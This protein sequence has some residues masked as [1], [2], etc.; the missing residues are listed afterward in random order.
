MEQWYRQNKALIPW[1]LLG[2]EAVYLLGQRLY[3]LKT[4]TEQDDFVVSSPLKT[5]LPTLSD[6]EAAELPYPPDAYPGARDVES[7]YGSLRVY[8]WG[9]EDG[10][11]VLLIHGISSPCITLGGIAHGLVDKGCRVILLDLPGRG[12]SD[13][14]VPTPHS[15]RLYTTII[16]LA[17]A[18]SPISW[19]GN[20]NR[21]SL[22]GYSFGGGIVANFTSYFPTLVESLVLLAPGGLIR[23]EHITWINKFLYHTRLINETTLEGI[24]GRG[25]RKNSLL[26]EPG[27]TM[28]EVAPATPVAGELPRDGSGAAPQMPMLSRARPGITPA[29]VVAWQL[30]AHP[31]F[32]KAFMSGIRYGPTANQHVI[33][34]RI[35]ERLARQNASSEERYAKEGLQGGQV[36]VIGGSKDDLIVKDELKEDATEVFGSE[37]VR[38]EWVDAEHEIAVTRSEEIVEIIG[39][40]WQ[41]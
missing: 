38:F 27:K 12:Y 10:R 15:T 37:D 36:L 33:W 11:K 34:R 2:F 9:P 13:T 40:F 41:L 30:D 39:S 3:K 20:T 31:G 14:P 6:A 1:A 26:V 19:T 32:V 5:L 4:G 16:L 29:K 25:L 18:S 22:I 7:P 17:I 23:P 21:F 8:E 35:G 28:E 24:I